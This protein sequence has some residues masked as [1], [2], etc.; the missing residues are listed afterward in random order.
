MMWLVDLS[1]KRPVLAVMMIGALVVLGWIS[2][3]RLGVDLFPDVEF[4][5]VAVTTTLEGASPDTMETEVSDVIEESVNTISGIKQL[6]STSADGLSQVFI[7]FELEENVDVKAQDVRD[8]VNIA[9]RDLPEDIDPPVIEKVDPD[10]APIMSVMIA[11]DAPIGDITT[12]ADE[13]VKEA[14]QRLP[15]VGSVTI[16]GGRL[17][18]IRI[19]LDADKM[20]AFGVTAEDIVRAVRSEHAEVPG[21]RLETGGGAR[22]FGTKTVSEAATPREFE[23]LVVAFRDSGAPTRIGDVARVEDGLEDERSYAEFNARPG[24]SLDVRRQSGRNTL[25]V[26]EAVYAEIERLKAVAP[27]GYELVVA[28]DVSRFIES[29]VEDVTHELEIAIVLVV[30]VTFFFLLSWRA[31][32]MVAIAIPTSLISAFFAFEVFDFT[33]NMLTLLALTVT[34]GLLVDDAIVVVESVQRDIDAGVEPA[35]AARQGTERVA[36]AVLAGTFATLA[37]FV[38]IA[39]MEGVVGR[40]FLQYGLAIVFAVSVSLLVALTLTPMLAS[41]FLRPESQP[42]FLRPIEKFHHQLDQ[43]Y[44]RI[45]GAVVR[46][47]YVALAAAIGSLFVGGFFASKVPSGFTSKADRS[48]FLGSIELPLGSGIAESKKAIAL[49][50][51]ALRG[52]KHIENIFLTA[53]AGSQ[54][55]ANVIDLYASITPKQERRIGQFE[56]MDAARQALV[57]AVP[58]AK[59]ITVAEVPWISGGGVS[60]GDVELV[61]RGDA[62]PEIDAYVK[63]VMSLMRETSLYSDLRS[64]F[65]EGRPELLIDFN[66]TRAGDLGVSART[67]ATTAR[68]VIGGVDA[69]SFEEGGKRYDVRVRLEESQRQDRDQLE[70]IQ[71]RN[72]SGRL[73]DLASVASMRFASG[74]SQI[75]RQDRA[76]KISILA[77]TASGVALGT[78]TEALEAIIAD[79]PPPANMRISYEGSV[80]RMNESISAIMFAF[81]LAM[82]ALYIVLASQFNSFVQ[83]IVIMLT[84]PLSFSGAF[85]MLYFG[86]QEMS[87][88]AQIG[89][90]ALMGIVMKNGILLVDRANQLREE[91]AE[92]RDA[93]IKAC[94]ERLRPVLMTAFAAIFGMIPVALSGSDGAEWRN[95]LGYLIIGGLSSSTILTLLVVPAAYMV[96]GDL[97]TITKRLIG[98]LKGAFAGGSTAPDSAS[99]KPAE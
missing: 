8:K 55:K 14:V 88:F 2:M 58:E 13:V 76:R 49:A 53:G 1:I 94:P 4:P 73:I 89:L 21:G 11:A 66:R 24:V 62:I 35:K 56:V 26:A 40:F 22:E 63:M 19:W 17:R 84:A 75:E 46:W 47:R 93:I 72:E 10:A 68:T 45:V 39:F 5:Y 20:R 67:L 30:I 32:L 78:A 54:G 69:G 77:N 97:N 9:R 64:S 50:N 31:T 36:L 16:V 6:R 57:A 33:I 65:E 52:V 29:S 27:E 80:R 92:T 71:V 86:G 83:P 37:V 38:P 81:G 95:G 98:V 23:D 82:I 70:L 96:P 48:E 60:T 87:L 28:R 79:N 12:Y 42:P 44:S 99:R 34:I 85:A 51:E 59:E 43:I 90:I 74:P 15:G 3:G 61:V 7:E 41:R 91:G 25:E 18:E